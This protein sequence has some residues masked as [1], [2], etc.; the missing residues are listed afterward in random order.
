LRVLS[1]AVVAFLALF[2]A[3]AVS[4]ADPL[5]LEVNAL[6]EKPGLVSVVVTALDSAGKPVTDIN[7]SNFTATL[8]GANVPISSVDAP[9]NGARISTGIVLL[10]DVSGSMYGEPIVGA[11]TALGEFVKNLET[12]DQ[13]AVLAFS[14]S[15]TT[16]QDFTSNRNQINAGINKLTAFGDTALY[17]AV[18][19]GTRKA[20]EL[21]AS[22]K[23]VVLLSDGVSTVNNGAR[24]ASIEAARTAGVSIVS[25]GFGTAIDRE[26]L[27]TV[28]DVSGGRVI[29]AVTPDALRQAYIDLAASIRSRYTVHVTIPPTADRTI[30]ANFTLKLSS[31]AGEATIERQ[32][33]PLA[34]AKVPSFSVK[35]A[36]IKPNQEVAG[37]QALTPQPPEGVALAQVEYLIDGQSAAIA[38]EAPFSHTLDAAALTPGSHI[39]KVIATDPRG[40]VAETEVAFIVPGAAGKS[41]L[42]T[43]LPI[44]LVLLLLS[45]IG[46]GGYKVINKRLQM[47]EANASDNVVRIMP[48]A[49]TKPADNL[50]APIDW[51]EKPAAP[52]VP[53][54]PI[55]GRIVVMDEAA[56]REGDLS[57]ITEY[58][59]SNAPLTL[60]A[61]PSCDIQIVDQ[62][63]I[64]MEEAR[65][66]VQKGRLVYH[67]LTTLSAMAT[68]GVTSGWLLLADGEELHLGKYRILFQAEIPV[69]SDL[70]AEEEEHRP[71]KQFTGWSV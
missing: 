35:L 22:R 62:D 47:H 28:S 14:N 56:I 27:Q 6:E 64:D 3:S 1:F 19:A 12:G 39:V 17:D 33:G 36:G 11:R 26:Y 44:L 68:E 49:K 54:N 42:A 10:V 57:K 9:G 66:W 18:I 21:Q 7:A 5:R 71:N 8:N 23:I 60:G 32:L 46:F 50:S 25:I 43:L 53:F 59:I 4:A 16:L 24:D 63:N 69:V 52:V 65:L 67:K 37:T 70:E 34:G 45:G 2:V 29:E 31:R 20:A 41:P 61:G 48:F 13:V 15:V 38:K 55:H 40:A 30:P 51:P 58:P